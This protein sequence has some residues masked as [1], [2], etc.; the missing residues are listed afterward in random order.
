MRDF[1]IQ[2]IF[3]IVRSLPLFL[4]LVMR[5]HSLIMLRRAVNSIS[6][7]AETVVDGWYVICDRLLVSLSGD[8]QSSTP[9]LCLF[10]CICRNAAP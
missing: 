7:E 2:I 5:H 4:L 3:G 8:C 1:C 10:L 9:E 6:G